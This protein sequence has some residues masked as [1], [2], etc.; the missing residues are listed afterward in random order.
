MLCCSKTSRFTLFTEEAEAFVPRR[1]SKDCK[2]TKLTPPTC[3][4]SP[5]RS[6]TLPRR[7]RLL[8]DAA[9]IALS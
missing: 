7:G 3:K 6:R 9:A 2:P 8:D 1:L 4:P 5:M